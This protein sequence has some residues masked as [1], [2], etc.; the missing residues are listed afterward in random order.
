MQKLLAGVERLTLG[1]TV[2]LLGAMVITTGL[3][4]ISRYVFKT[5]L[6]WTEETGRHLMVWMVFLG[7]SVIYR[8]GQHIS[9]DLLADALRPRGKAILGLITA[10]VSAVFFFIIL[11]NGWELLGRTMVQKSSALRYPMAYAY[12]ALP[13]SGA[14]MLVYSLEKAVRDLLGII[15]PET[16]VPESERAGREP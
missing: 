2:L 3:Q 8:R 14:L 11:T 5:P 13:V 6:V 1:V 7:T 4:V 10:L 12:A 16:Y 9:I 15:N